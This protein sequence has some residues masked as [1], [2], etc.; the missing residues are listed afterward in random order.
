MN[1]NDDMERELRR[2]LEDSASRPSEGVWRRV[3]AEVERTPQRSGRGGSTAWPNAFWPRAITFLTV[4]IAG[5]LVGAVIARS[6]WL[7]ANR[8]SSTPSTVLPTGSRPASETPTQTPD[9]GVAGFTTP[10]PPS[11]G[12]AWARLTWR[13][14]AAT[15]PLRLVQRVVG[16]RGGYLAIGRVVRVGDRGR[17]P[18]WLSQDGKVWTALPEAVFGKSTVV[19]DIAEA[20][21]GLVALTAQAGSNECPPGDCWTITGPVHAWTSEDG[22]AWV[23]RPAPDF[24]PPGESVDRVAMV[25][26]R[27]GIVAASTSLPVVASFSS[28]G[29]TWRTITKAFP[30]TFRLAGLWARV[31]GFAAVGAVDVD[32]SH[33]AGLALWSADGES[34]SPAAG[35]LVTASSGIT[36][37]SSGPT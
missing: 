13:K 7:T 12:S 14:L 3:L 5:V 26:G 17:T 1:Q 19:M 28:D 37:P 8:N 15:D 9:S 32:A 34:W 11:A 27:A 23:A 30:S 24:L 10:A 29:I 35:P 20:P 31:D 16:W 36:L 22:A 2:R 25:S 6:D 33:Q 21:S 4:V 18:V